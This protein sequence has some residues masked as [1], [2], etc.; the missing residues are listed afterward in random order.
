MNKEHIQTIIAYKDHNGIS[1]TL[2]DVLEF[3]YRDQG[4]DY[5]DALNKTLEILGNLEVKDKSK[6]EFK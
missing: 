6:F 1:W 2:L 3:F 4:L 5:D